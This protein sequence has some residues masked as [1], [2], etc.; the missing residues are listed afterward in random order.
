MSRLPYLWSRQMACMGGRNTAA[1][2]PART[3]GR[4]RKRHSRARY[5]RAPLQVAAR[6]IA[7]LDRPA[8]PSGETAPVQRFN[9]EASESD[10][11]NIQSKGKKDGYSKKRISHRH[12]AAGSYSRGGVGFLGS[13]SLAAETIGFSSEAAKN[14]G[15][16]YGGTITFLDGYGAAFPPKSWH[17]GEGS[18]WTT[19]IYHEP[20]YETLMAADIEKFGP[21][22]LGTSTFHH[23][24]GS[25]LDFLRGRLAESWSLPD[26][27]TIIF[28]LRP[29]IMW[30]G[31]PGVMESRELTAEDVVHSYKVGWPRYNWPVFEDVESVTATD[32]HTVTI[33]NKKFI[34][35]WFH[36]FGFA[37]WNGATIVPREVTDEAMKD[38]KTHR[39]LG[40]GP[41]TLEDYVEGSTVSYVRNPNYWDSYVFN[42]K[43][44]EIS[45]IDRLVKTLI[46]DKSSQVAALRTGKIDV[47]DVLQKKFVDSVKRSSPEIKM[48]ERPAERAW[49]IGMRLDV[50]PF[51]DLRVR[52]AISMAIDREAFINTL[53]GGGGVILNAELH[54]GLPETLYTPLEKLP[55][56]T[57]ENF[58]YDPERARQLLAEAGYPDGFKSTI[59]AYAREPE[60]DVVSF[61]TA[62]WK[63]IGIDVK[64]DLRD[65]ATLDG[66]LNKQNEHAPITL[67]ANSVG[68]PGNT[69]SSFA[70]R[71][72]DTYQT[73]VVDDPELNE[74]YAQWSKTIDPVEGDKIMKGLNQ[75]W[76]A[77]AYVAYA[78]TPMVSIAY[79]PWVENYAGETNDSSAFSVG[80]IFAR[81]WINSDL[82]AEILGQ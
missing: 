1:D 43:E 13:P 12:C 33:K 55:Q 59:Q 26:A 34:A 70:I 25:N 11:V 37:H 10:V 60:R 80:G 9:S 73:A 40:T 28:K 78:P 63:D 21:R 75:L 82:K 53:W 54:S 69:L 24:P 6:S 39:G 58:E 29:G 79:W 17:K 8:A 64:I 45:F 72:Q 52:K 30:S 23:S 4:H 47:Y 77:K 62:M 15:P 81:A 56:S 46:Q 66:I 18:D 76:L 22:G 36:W 74:I 35:E 44:Y 3:L 67:L 49:R 5:L 32:R 71:E 51:D 61:L 16:Q 65:S 7:P 48:I 2:G 42:G 38:W 31:K 41:F 27:N 14:A 20:M 68:L 50:K 57:R 19:G